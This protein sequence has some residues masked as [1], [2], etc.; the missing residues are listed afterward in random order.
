MTPLAENQRRAPAGTG[1]ALEIVHAH[2]HPATTVAVRGGPAERAGALAEA[3]RLLGVAVALR[4]HAKDH[5]VGGI[6]TDSPAK[7]REPAPGTVA[8]QAYEPVSV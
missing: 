3:D 4:G 7:C 2:Y 5:D 6:A 8:S 1:A